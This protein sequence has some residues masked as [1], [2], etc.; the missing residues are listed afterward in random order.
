[1]IEH[2]QHWNS[3]N[4]SNALKEKTA[5]KTSTMTA[6]KKCRFPNPKFSKRRHKGNPGRCR[7][8]PMS[9]D[10]RNL[11]T[12]PLGHTRGRVK[13]EHLCWGCGNGYSLEKQI[14]TV[15]IALKI[16]MTLLQQ[17]YFYVTITNIN[18][19]RAIA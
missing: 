10:A 18:N 16:L 6:F 13:P 15:L 4:P 3:E 9:D 11:V 1:M 12:T 17:I 2:S 8:G 14:F 7:G 5:E 19:S